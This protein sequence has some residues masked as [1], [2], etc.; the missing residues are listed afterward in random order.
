MAVT[1]SGT[2]GATEIRIR[3]SAPSGMENS[4]NGRRRPQR[5]LT[6]SDRMPNSGWTVNPQKLSMPMIMPTTAVGS[7][8]PFSLIG[9]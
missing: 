6:L 9:T 5:V 3:H 7:I 1:V 8:R 2:F 4:A